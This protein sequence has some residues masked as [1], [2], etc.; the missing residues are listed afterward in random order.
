MIRFNVLKLVVGGMKLTISSLVIS[1]VAV[2]LGEGTVALYGKMGLFKIKDCWY[3]LSTS[4]ELFLCYCQVSCLTCEYDSRRLLISS[5][6][7]LYRAFS[8]IN[9]LR[10]HFISNVMRKKTFITYWMTK[11]ESSTSFYFKSRSTPDKKNS[12]WLLSL[13]TDQHEYVSSFCA[14][15]AQPHYVIEH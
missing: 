14:C 11:T 8:L 4:E 2:F 15:Y 3:C 12:W 10:L 5:D 13:I 7:D 6:L 1:N 9:T